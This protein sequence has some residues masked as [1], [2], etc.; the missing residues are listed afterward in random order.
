MTTAN[1]VVVIIIIIVIN[2]SRAVQRAL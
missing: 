2:P 1:V